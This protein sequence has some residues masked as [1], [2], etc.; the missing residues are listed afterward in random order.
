M[1]S[2]DSVMTMRTS[3][4]TGSVPDP[5]IYNE[6]YFNVS[7]ITET[8]TNEL[9]S[10]CSAICISFLDYYSVYMLKRNILIG[11]QKYTEQVRMH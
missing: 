1:I 5:K 10:L 9:Q 4:N 7:E 8:R 3:S 6:R 11:E 2:D